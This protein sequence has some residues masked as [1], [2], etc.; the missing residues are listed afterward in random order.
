MIG[1]VKNSKKCQPILLLVILIFSSLL[2]YVRAQQNRPYFSYIDEGHVV[3]HAQ[4]M[5]KINSLHP[6]W[7]GYGSVL[8]NL[9]NLHATVVHSISGDLEDLRK[10]V[11]VLPTGQLEKFVGED[12]VEEEYSLAIPDIFILY[13]RMIVILCFLMSVYFVFLISQKLLRGG[14]TFVA[15]LALLTIPVLNE[16][17][18]YV[19][20]DIV[21]MCFITMAAF[22]SMKWAESFKLP[23][24]MGAGLLCGMAAGAKYTGAAS[25]GIPFL[26]VLLSNLKF[27]KKLTFMFVL[28]LTL[29]AGF[30][31]SSP[32]MIGHGREALESF[33]SYRSYYAS[34]GGSRWSY[35]FQMI[36]S[37]VFGLPLILFSV[38]GFLYSVKVTS[39]KKI[40]GIFGF[41]CAAYFALFQQYSNQPIR[42]IFPIFPFLCIFSAYGIIS[43]VSF[44]NLKLRRI[45]APALGALLISILS[46]NSFSVG[47]AQHRQVNTRIQLT[48]WATHE[49][50]EGDQ[51][52]YQGALAFHHSNI[53]EI[54][55]KTSSKFFKKMTFDSS[56]RD[57]N[58]YIFPEIEK[59]ELAS[60]T[61]YQDFLKFLSQ[62]KFKLEKVF[63]SEKSSYKQNVFKAPDSVIYVYKNLSEK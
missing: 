60:R 59:E 42:N 36:D 25:I 46:W 9:I 44:F 54:E 41:W 40:I 13:G 37:R 12:E 50:K 33:L 10:S 29:I 31:V 23:L 48:Q 57:W 58:Y 39:E 14:M 17:T 20:N 5:F 38:L 56:L 47:I 45:T 32:G 26:F 16:Y 61:D 2:H 63:G 53:D 55:K 4:N 6:N 8:M 43:I 21:M 34:K 1:F 24:L 22:L 52:F 49:F 35:F 7:Y 15:P 11:K 51:V 28:G 62:N 18:I 27:L 19:H 3:R 30:Y